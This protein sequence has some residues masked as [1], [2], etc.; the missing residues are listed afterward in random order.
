ML[1]DGFH[2]V[3]LLE[4]DMIVFLRKPRSV[5]LHSFQVTV[6]GYPLMS[7]ED[8]YAMQLI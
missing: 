1:V 6:H 8:K 4:G 5:C 2:P 3:F 7:L